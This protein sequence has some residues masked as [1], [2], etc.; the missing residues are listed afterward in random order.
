M[1]IQ[2]LKDGAEQAKIELSSKME[3][4]INLPFLT[5]DATGPKHL[6]KNL[7]R[8]K[9]EQMMRPLIERS[10]EPVKRALADAKKR[11]Q[12]IDEVV[13]VGGST[14]IPSV[15]EAVKAFFGKEPHKGVNPD[16][17]V[18]I[19]AAVQ[20]GVLS[21]DVKDM[22]LLDV[23]PLSLGVETLGSVMTVMIPRN[24]TIP[25]AKKETFS[26]AA[27]SQPS[28]EIHVLQGERTE[29]RYNRTLGR[30]H[31]E[32]IIPAP[33]GVPKIEVNFDIDANGILN[34]TAKDMATGRDQR[35]TIT[36][37]SGLSDTQIKD[38]VKDAE[39]NEAE[40]KKRLEEVGRRNKLDNMC[41][42]LD[43]TLRENKDKLPASDVATLEGIIQESKKAIEVQDDAKVTE[44]LER[45]EKEAHRVASV[46]YQQAGSGQDGAPPTGG[47]PGGEAGGN[48]KKRDDVIDADFEETV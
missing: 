15:V 7:S 36:A 47:A 43:K 17:V 13:L 48:G 16:E 11:P 27:D 41:Y 21:G 1:V 4:Q 23:T 12:E 10:M 9:L 2:R 31:L 22:V 45:L 37:G 30:F 42:Q 33:R 38:M 14:R 8:A 40:D 5:A 19:G 46:L 26:T 44:A 3:T 32:G 29:A 25:F 6:Q 35:I 28:V 24:T 39:V 18:A 20:A 34:V